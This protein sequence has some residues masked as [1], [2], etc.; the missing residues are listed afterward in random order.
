[1]ILTVFVGVSTRKTKQIT[2][3]AVSILHQR[4]GGWPARLRVPTDRSIFSR[5][6]SRGDP[7]L[8]PTLKKISQ[9]PFDSPLG[10]RFLFCFLA[11]QSG[12]RLPYP[13]RLST[14]TNG[15]PRRSDFHEAMALRIL[16]RGVRAPKA[17]V[18]EE[19]LAGGSG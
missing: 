7:A 4:N 3:F 18:P 2:R 14:Q 10:Y 19:S 9:W 5:G 6:P 12:H 8:R 11:A 13:G 17:L 1:L 16:G 15:A